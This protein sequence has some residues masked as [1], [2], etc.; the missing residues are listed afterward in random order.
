MSVRTEDS[1]VGSIVKDLGGQNIAQGFPMKTDGYA[2]FSLERVVAEDPDVILVQCMGEEKVI[3]QRIQKQFASNPAWKNLR[4]VKQKRYY[5]L[6]KELFL[7][8]PNARWPEA[9]RKMAQL[10]TK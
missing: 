8:K 3:A 2:T 10:L 5:V 9:Y 4:A 7:Y 6:P 1:H